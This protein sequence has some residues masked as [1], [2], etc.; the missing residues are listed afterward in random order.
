MSDDFFKELKVVEL[1]SVLAGPSVGLFFA[2]QGAR[3]LKVENKKTGGD[4]TRTWKLASENPESSVSAYFSSVNFKKNYL[5]LDLSDKQDYQNLL[6][7]LQDTDILITNFKKGDDLKFQLDYGTLKK[8]NPRL[9]YGEISGYGAESER[10]AYDLILQADSGFMSMNGT[11]ESGPVKMPVALIDL[12]AGHQL[13]EGIL[14]ALINRV[15]SNKGCK[16][17]VSLFESAVASLANQASNWLME[18]HNPKPIGSKHPNISPYGDIYKT[19]DQKLVTL[20][21]GNDKQFSLLCDL[22]S[23]PDLKSDEKYF[24][25]QNRVKN[26]LELEQILQEQISR[27]K[28]SELM[29]L[30]VQKQ[31]PGAI[32]KT[33]EEVFSDPLT[34]SLINQELIDGKETKRVKTVVY[35]ISH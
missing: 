33:V 10:V 3:V 16:V 13:K 34:G 17:S 5:Y 18:K 32:I 29:D 7:E 9:I 27:F 30:L 15:K 21:I 1:A 24:S 31:I 28:S 6:N 35:R 2:E 8:L 26:R 20:A 22:L 19:A 25:N 23:L 4:V 11:P 12:L 14:V